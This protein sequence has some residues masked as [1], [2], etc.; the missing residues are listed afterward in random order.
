MNKCPDCESYNHGFGSKRCLQCHKYVE[1]LK[2]STRRNQVPISVVPQNILE[3]IEDESSGQIKTIL[4]AIRS[5]PPQLSLIIAG[6]Y[7]CGLSYRQ[8]ASSL[9]LSH[10]SVDKKNKFAIDIIKKITQ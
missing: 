6:V 7:V 10:Q 3:A 2:N 9:H 5:L 1:I 8:L 4:H